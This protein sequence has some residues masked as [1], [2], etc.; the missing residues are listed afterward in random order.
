[1]KKVLGILGVLIVV[2]VLT[3]VLNPNFVTAHNLQ[4]ILQRTALYGILGIGVAFVIMSG[5]I[6][7]SIGSVVGLVG[8]LVPILIMQWR[9]PVAVVVLAVLAVTAAIGLA[10]GLLITKLRLQPFA[11]TL[12]GLLLYRGVARWVAEDRTL[13]FGNEYRGL[14]QAV[15]GNLAIPFVEGFQVPVPFL[16]M[17][18]IA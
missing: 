17:L 1:M 9:W 7:L 2:V 11:V 3:S 10:H 5:G 18:V 16:I 4:N 12:C 13:G 6:D 14:R 8:C 15:T